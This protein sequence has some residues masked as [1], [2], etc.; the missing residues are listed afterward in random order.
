M[1]I[2]LRLAKRK[3]IRLTDVPLGFNLQAL[4]PALFEHPVRRLPAAF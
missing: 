2:I 4:S 3:N 1:G